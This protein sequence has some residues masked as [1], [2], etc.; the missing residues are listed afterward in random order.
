[1]NPLVK[2]FA[3]ITLCTFPGLEKSTAN[4]RS[5]DHSATPA[6]IQAAILLDVSGSMNGLIE[7]AKALLWN[8]VTTLGKTQ[9]S[10]NSSPQVELAL[11]EYGRATNDVAK[12]YVKQLSPFTSDLDEISKILFSLNTN[13]SDEYCGQVIYTSIDELKWDASAGNYKVIF[14]AGNEDFLQGSLHYTKACTKAKEK[15]VIVNTIYCG[16]YKTGLA[17][18][19]N[20]AGECGNGSFT[21][22]NQNANEF[23][24]PTPYDTT[25]IV[26]NN[27]LN[28]TYI[29]YGTFGYT[30]K[31][32]QEK[33]DQLNFSKSKNLTAE[34][35]EAK[36]KSKVYS[37][38]SWD[39]VDANTADSTYITR[40][41]RK[42]LPDSLKNKTTAQL[43]QIVKEKTTMRKAIQEEV[44]TVNARRSK[45]ITE[46]K[47][48]AALNKN[49]PTL[50]SEVDKILRE[51]VKRF[52]MKID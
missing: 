42:T 5:F 15:G 22:I 30:N 6:K 16:D 28:D 10:D 44:I 2:L 35:M 20:L 48:K 37:N 19:W 12:G 1:M 8:M 52:N 23:D 34:R 43:Q 36:A 11:Y 3:S 14:I 9:C 25:L 4:N 26:L 17:E 47:S 45:Y 40:V 49:E 27:K 21:N 41:D 31:V 29:G 46:Q 24:I 39:L 33:V 7:Q 50:E 32:R 38:S 13:G 18:H 51:Q